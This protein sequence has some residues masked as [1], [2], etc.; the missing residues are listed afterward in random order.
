MASGMVN[1]EPREIYGQYFSLKGMKGV[2]YGNTNKTEY[3]KKD[4]VT[5]LFIMGLGK[6]PEMGILGGIENGLKIRFNAGGP[7]SDNQIGSVLQSL[8]SSGYQTLK[9][10]PGIGVAAGTE[11]EG[12]STVRAYA[13]ITRN[14]WFTGCLTDPSPAECKAYDQ[15]LTTAL[16][17]GEEPPPE[18]KQQ[19]NTK[20]DPAETKKNI[21]FAEKQ[22]QEAE[23]QINLLEDKLNR[24]KKEIEGLKQKAKQARKLADQ[25]KAEFQKKWEDQKD[26]YSG[27][28]YRLQKHIESLEFNIGLQKDIINGLGLF[29]FKARKE[30]KERLAEI[31]AEVAALKEKNTKT[32]EISSK[33][34][35]E[36]EPIRKQYID[37]AN[38][39]EAKYGNAQDEIDEMQEDLNSTRKQLQKYQTL[40]KQIQDG[41]YSGPSL[42]KAE[43]KGKTA[44][45]NHA[46]NRQ[47]AVPHL[48][49]KALTEKLYQEMFLAG[50]ALTVT[51]IKNLSPYFAD[52]S[53]PKINALL[54]TLILDYKVEKNDSH[55][56]VALYRAL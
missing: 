12:A 45:N 8:T 25:K 20:A 39:A 19:K 55:G 49:D 17:G 46:A 18:P 37:P 28:T 30:Q 1:G 56:P 36:W 3:E 38:E 15:L 6:E 35:T 21:E 26:F 48:D 33:R 11:T 16:P 31:E 4:E 32:K 42:V 50:K 51:E 43:K 23:A 40:L 10:E 47:K 53:A 29:A 24:R 2:I 41:T 13:L 14:G 44:A 27:D 7:I 34:D 52:L 9:K 5:T 22:I 54:K